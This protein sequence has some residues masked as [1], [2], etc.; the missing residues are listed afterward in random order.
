MNEPPVID[1][2]TDAELVNAKES[3][4][5]EGG[6]MDPDVRPPPGGR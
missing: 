6:S 5:S 1:V 4:V 2:D 3:W